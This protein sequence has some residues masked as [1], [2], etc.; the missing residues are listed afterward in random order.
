[1]K[2]NKLID[3]FYTLGFILAIT[4]VCVAGVSWAYQA[5]KAQ[6]KANQTLDLKRA[7]LYAAGIKVPETTNAIEKLFD[8]KL[9]KQG[10]RYIVENGGYVYPVVGTGLWGKIEAMIGVDK[11][12][13]AMTGIYFTGQNETPGL[14]ARIDEE[15]FKKQFKGKKP[16][17][18]TVAEGE[19]STD[20]Q[21][22]AIT[23][24]TITSNGVKNMV[25]E[26]FSEK[27]N[28]LEDKK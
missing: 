4:A 23:G 5:T 14:G 28:K 26:F 24:A 17:L 13:N 8:E 16:P 6:I 15:W 9:K 1:M 12:F 27:N 19:P 10:D 22:D 3:S 2:K 11:K 18:T 21:F 20:K 25:N 7:A